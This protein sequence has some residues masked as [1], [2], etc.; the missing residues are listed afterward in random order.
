[1]SAR[2]SP[3]DRRAG[4]S[5][6]EL[7]IAIVLLAVVVAKLTIVVGE[8]QDTQ[9]RQS[10]SMVLEDRALQVLDQIT[11]AIMGSNSESLLPDNEFPAHHNEL[12]Y[13]LSLGVEDGQVV[14]SDMELIGLNPDNPAQVQWGQSVGEPDERFVVWCNTVNEMLEDEILNG[15]DDNENGLADEAGLSFVLDDRAVRVR[16][17]L[18]GTDENGN[19]IEHTAETLVTCRN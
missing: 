1:M 11:Y 13:R 16:L 14:W 7:T 10:V 8:A 18:V 12:R 9:R 6:V 15:I 17:T 4:F 2:L 3:R 19:P 5:L